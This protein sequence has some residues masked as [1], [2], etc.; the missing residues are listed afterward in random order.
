MQQ[1]V[2]SDLSKLGRPARIL[3][4]DD[5]AQN[6]ELIE[7]VCRAEGFEAVGVAAGRDVV[8]AVR[9]EAFD[10]LLIDA[11]MPDL[12]GWE[13]C[14]ILRAEP[15]TFELPIIV[16]TATADDAEREAHASLGVSDIVAKPFR[17]FELVQRMRR[18]LRPR[19]RQGDPPTAPRV[20]L[21]RRQVDVLSALPSPRTLRARLAREIES[22]A[23]AGRPVL[24][25]VVRL[26]NE[27]ALSAKVGRSLTDALLGGIVAALL[28]AFPDQV[29]R[30]DLDEVVIL[31]GEEELKKLDAVAAD[32]PA[33]AAGLGVPASI[34]VKIRW[35]AKSVDPGRADADLLLDGARHAL[36]HAQQTGQP[37]HVDR[38]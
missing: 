16:V 6:R 27:S 1:P 14:R 25:A 12:N 2:D 5:D 13:V 22:C 18:A 20:R 9:R 8:E 35:G 3:V 36:D 7:E 33:F 28:D 17:V 31:V 37:S 32:A 10:L 34:D 29:V 26:E 19:S 30:S 4:A 38:T 15:A 21:R 24:C 11:S 23:R